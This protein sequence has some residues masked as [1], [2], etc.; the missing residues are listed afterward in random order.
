MKANGDDGS[1]AVTIYNIGAI[2][3]RIF[4]CTDLPLCPTKR[5]PVSPAHNVGW[6]SG[7]V[8]KVMGN[9]APTG[10]QTPDGPGPGEP[11]L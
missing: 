3:W 5:D 6:A 2:W 4:N 7:Y 9:L 11:P 1:K 10:V 8:W